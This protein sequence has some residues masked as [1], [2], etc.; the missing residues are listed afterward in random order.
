MKIRVSRS[1]YAWIV[2]GLIFY[3][4]MTT[5]QTV[6]WGS[7]M[8]GAIFVI[9]LVFL[10][11][12]LQLYKGL[13][14]S[15][16]GRLFWY[17]LALYSLIGNQD[18]AQDTETRWILPMAGILMLYILSNH[19]SWQYVFIK[20]VRFF[21]G[22]HAF[23]TIF[24][25]VFKGLYL[26]HFV[27]FLPGAGEYLIGKFKDGCMPG[28]TGH[29]SMNGIYL[30]IGFVFFAC[31][32]LADNKTITN[33]HYRKEAVKTL[34]VLLALVL[35]SKRAHILFGMIS[36]FVIYYVYHSD[37]KVRRWFYIIGA[38]L[39]LGL[40]VIAL[41]PFVPAIS[42]MIHR[43]IY[44]DGGEI[45]NGRIWFWEFA[46]EKFLES[47]IV[48]IGW[49]GFKHAYYQRIGTYSST[50]IFVDTHNVY[51]Q[52]LCEQGLIG[53]LLFISGIMAVFMKTWN[54]LK[55]SRRKKMPHIDIT[56]QKFLS[57]S[58]GIQAFF[59]MYCFTGNCLYD[60]E[61]FFV[62]IICCALPYEIGK[63]A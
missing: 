30:G 42:R 63:S 6:I 43:F 33:S 16:D 57:V 50:S 28:I 54:L 35:T 2:A 53:F 47:P 24:F 52:I 60:C 14:I 56:A 4:Y 25:Y 17:I 29:Y 11:S 51:L 39:G 1:P 59:I 41:L 23:F 13:R 55:S 34:F 48:G 21:T 45:T 8:G 46:L 3:A 31:E 22:I 20:S 19:N 38:G 62:Y 32:L 5:F 10:G 9:G 49:G 18:L 7:R 40:L 61:F 12:A 27:R 58:L 37:Q 44:A 15:A 26:N 36:C